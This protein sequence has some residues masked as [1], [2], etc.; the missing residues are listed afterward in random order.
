LSAYAADWFTS[1]TIGFTSGALAG[2]SFEIK[3]H[4]RTSGVDFIQLWL[5][6]P[7]AVT[8][9]DTATVTAGCIKTFAICKSKFDNHLNFSG[10]PHIPSSDV[11]T[12]YG[13]QGVGSGGG[14]L[15][16]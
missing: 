14:S 4:Q 2:L 16:E 10:F 9:G 7:F 12:R 5:P 11:V 6:P 8:A 15:L 3:A 13:T 1:G